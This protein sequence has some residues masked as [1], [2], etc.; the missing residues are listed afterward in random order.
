MNA[1]MSEVRRWLEFYG[2]DSETQ[3][4]LAEFWPRLRDELPGILDRFY[5]HMRKW[6]DAAGLFAQPGSMER[7][8]KGQAAHW[9][10]LFSGRFDEDYLD[11]VR[12]IGLVHSRVGVDTKTY[13]GGYAFVSNAVQAV[14]VRQYASRLNPASAQEKTIRLVQ[15][16]NKAMLFDTELTIIVYLD[17][18]RAEFAERLDQLAHSFEGSVTGVVNDIASA[19]ASLE[20]TA[21]GMSKTAQG[22]FERSASLEDSGNRSTESVTS[23]AGAAEEL[24][25]SIKEIDHQV[26][27]AGGVIADAV[28]QAAE[29]KGQVNGLVAATEK[30]SEVVKLIGDVAQQ[31]NLLALNATIE[32]ARAGTAGKGFAVVASEVKAL[33]DQTARA[34]EDI[35]AQ[36]NAVREAT[37]LSV[38]GIQAIVDTIG[39]VH[40]SA[41]GIGAA[42]EEQG[43]VTADIARSMDEAARR[44]NDVAGT[45]AGVSDDARITGAAAADVAAAAEQLSRGGDDLKVRVGDFLRSMHSARA[46]V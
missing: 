44:C 8:A 14:A 26:S 18:T 43:A 21:R 9:E 41:S 37:K 23:V 28:K 27:F 33:A 38:K 16:L 3:S 5:Q 29:T 46:S 17:R 31:T 36:I 15:A 13:V 7:A 40:D 11:S 35:T 22:A 39:K 24:S 34:T 32:A 12:H 20:T 45:I 10:K 25:A 30:I 2:I 19:A 6:P 4:I 42:V 1:R